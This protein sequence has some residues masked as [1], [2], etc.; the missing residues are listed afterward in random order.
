MRPIISQILTPTYQ[1]AN[2]LNKFII[3]Y[4]PNEYFLK[5]TDEF[6][7]NLENNICE[8]IFASLDVESVFTNVP[9]EVTIKTISDCLN[10]NTNLLPLN[11]PQ[12]I[13]EE[14]EI[15]DS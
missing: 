4:I 1:L 2:S 7:D 13:H 6:I 5:S 9:V 15:L 10:K 3:Q 11:I 8:R 14:L 12:N